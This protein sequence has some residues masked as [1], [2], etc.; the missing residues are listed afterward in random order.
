MHLAVMPLLGSHTHHIRYKLLATLLSRMK[1][2]GELM[3]D[4]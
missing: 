3:A 4:G 1:V 2:N